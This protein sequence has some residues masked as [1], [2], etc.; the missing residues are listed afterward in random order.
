M[1]SKINSHNIVSRLE[2][3]DL[4]DDC[5]VCQA[6]KK[7]KERGYDLSYDELQVAFD[8]ANKLQPN[9]PN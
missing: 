2:D 9:K 3:E 7:A 5:P 1:I 8:E 4:F 6:L